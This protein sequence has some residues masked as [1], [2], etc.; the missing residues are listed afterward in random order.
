MKE[1]GKAIKVIKKL[2]SSRAEAKG[3]ITQTSSGSGDNIGHSGSGNNYGGHSYH[4]QNSGDMYYGN[5]NT[6]ACLQDL[7]ITD[8]R[9]NKKRIEETKG[10]LLTDSYRWILG[11]PDFQQ[12]HNGEQSK[13]L[14]VRGD[15]GKGKTI[16]L[17]GIIDELTKTANAAPAS[18]RCLVS[19]FFCQAIEPRFNNTTAVLRGLIYLL[20]DQ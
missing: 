3:S 7:R 1:L 13:L 18:G 11:N 10:S 17:C 4:I 2:P 8:P 16:L 6:N 19:Y 9:D 14:W 12:W 20:A 15:P 5:N